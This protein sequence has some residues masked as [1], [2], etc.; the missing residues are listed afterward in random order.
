MEFHIAG[1]YLNLHVETSVCL[2]GLVFQ[3]RNTTP[4]PPPRKKWRYRGNT[5]TGNPVVFIAANRQGQKQ[6]FESEH[7]KVNKYPNWPEA[8]QS[9]TLQAWA[10][11]WTRDYGEQIQLVVGA[12]LELG[13]SGL[14]F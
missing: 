9:A 14:Q 12:G 13:A 1:V 3:W 6:T 8:N 7:K 2:R 10:R 5:I 4:P 11:I